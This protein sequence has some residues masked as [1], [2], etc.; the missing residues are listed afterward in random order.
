MTGEDEY[1]R[2]KHRRYRSTLHIPICVRYFTLPTGTVTQTDLCS[3]QINRFIDFCLFCLWYV[4]EVTYIVELLHFS[5][6]HHVSLVHT[7]RLLPATGG[8][9]LRPR[10]TTHTLELGL[11]VSA[12][13]Q[14]WWP[15][16]DPWSPAMM[17]PLTLAT[18][19]FNLP[20]CPSCSHSRPQINATYR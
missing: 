5:H 12:V 6:F 8:S 15:R 20:S 3:H 2:Y 1:S 18:G 11:P 16:R 19:Y 13:L 7:N 9:G 17:G 4:C 10:G 14:Q